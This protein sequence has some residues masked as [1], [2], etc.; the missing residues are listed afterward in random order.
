VGSRFARHA[1]H[2]IAAPPVSA[3][4]AAEE[5]KVTPQ[6]AASALEGDVCPTCES[7]VVVECDCAQGD[8][9]VQLICLGC[10]EDVPECDCVGVVVV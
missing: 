9:P 2:R 5:V 7:N 8:P 6:N 10:G 4:A 3:R 1:H